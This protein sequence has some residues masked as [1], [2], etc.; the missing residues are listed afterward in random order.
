MLRSL[1][2]KGGSDT[3]DDKNDDEMVGGAKK[4]TVK[5]IAKKVETKIKL[6]KKILYKNRKRTVY[7]TSSSKT[8]YVQDSVT[9]KFIRVNPKDFT[10][11]SK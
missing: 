8:F 6:E 7:T 2:M 1:L 3:N 5:K 4:N 10:V 11:I 9:K